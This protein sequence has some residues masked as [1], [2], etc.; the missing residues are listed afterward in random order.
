MKPLTFEE[1]RER[2]KRFDE[3]TLLELLNIDSSDIVDAF[4]DLIEEH[5]E[6]LLKEVDE[7]E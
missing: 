7:D 5:Q 3:A 2:Q 6:K 1:L 4:N